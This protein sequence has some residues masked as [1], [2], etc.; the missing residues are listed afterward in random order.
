MARKRFQ[1][2]DAEYTN[3]DGLADPLISPD[4]MCE[5]ADMPCDSLGM[6]VKN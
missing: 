1:L 5:A 4:A 3:L 6:V 2:D